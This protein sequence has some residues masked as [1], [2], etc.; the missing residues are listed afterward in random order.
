MSGLGI[1]QTAFQDHLIGA[2]SD[3]AT[4][5]R[6]NSRVPVEIMLGIYEHAYVARLTECLENDFPALLAMMGKE[7]F[8]LLARG[9]VAAYPSRNPSVRWLGQYLADYIANSTAPAYHTSLAD[10]A[11]F[12][13][14]LAHAFDAADDKTVSLSDIA[15]MDPQSWAL[16]RF[17]FAA[18]VTSVSLTTDAPETRQK[19]LNGEKA[20]SAVLPAPTRW[21]VWRQ[22]LELRFHPTD[23]DEAL[24]FDLIRNGGTF[25]EMCEALGA[26]L[27][28]DAQTLRAAQILK[29]WLDW[30]MIAHVS[31]KDMSRGL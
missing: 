28:P 16:L 10:M 25:G 22:D 5:L 9:Y 15:T 14:A 26:T 4:V 24:A 19:L 12:E 13:W 20:E 8:H 2:T 30:G 6:G 23:P 21:Y 29:A 11:R 7:R 17:D 3:I 27:S 31:L 1:T 18:S